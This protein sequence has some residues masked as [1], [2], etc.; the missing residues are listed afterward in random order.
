M[1]P[2]SGYGCMR[3][4]KRY[5]FYEGHTSTCTN[6]VYDN[7][8]TFHQSYFVISI[9]GSSTTLFTKT[10]CIPQNGN[11]RRLEIR[12]FHAASASP[13][14]PSTLSTNHDLLNY[15]LLLAIPLYITISHKTTQLPLRSPNNHRYPS[16][17]TTKP[18]SNNVQVHHS[19]GSSGARNPREGS[20]HH[21]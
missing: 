1:A 7:A 6:D 11:F 20:L 9:T 15:I 14:P 2:R 5:D 19:K 17:S 12:Y 18:Q 4:K 10:E 13:S 21:Y 8:F 16:T 3:G